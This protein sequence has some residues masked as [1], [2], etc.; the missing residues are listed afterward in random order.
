MRTAQ[1]LAF[2]IKTPPEIAAGAT[3]ITSNYARGIP[4]HRR[5]AGF[6]CVPPSNNLALR[7]L[8]GG[9]VTGA[10]QLLA[11]TR[12]YQHGT[13]FG[14]TNATARLDSNRSYTGGTSD[15][16]PIGRPETAESVAR[17]CAIQSAAFID[18]RQARTSCCLP[19][20]NAHS[21]TANRALP[22][23]D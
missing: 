13:V 7:F 6:G 10:L 11:Q 8:V 12:S 1:L 18:R 2:A 16:I 3:A 15:T 20:N 14:S 23:N 17:R 5:S 9:N 4:S 21:E 19:N 22:G